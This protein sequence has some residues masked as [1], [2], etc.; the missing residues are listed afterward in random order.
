MNDKNFAAEVIS[1]AGPG[2]FSDAESTP[3][4]VIFCAAVT[5]SH[6]IYLKDC[7]L[8]GD[9]ILDLVNAVNDLPRDTFVINTSSAPVLFVEIET[10][11]FAHEEIFGAG[12]SMAEAR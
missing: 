4:A 7:A 3:D 11:L 1:A 8:T 5:D 6:T 9:E 2:P 12:G 10:D